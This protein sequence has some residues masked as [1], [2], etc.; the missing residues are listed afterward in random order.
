MNKKD[1]KPVESGN[2]CG[3]PAT[4]WMTLLESNYGTVASD[5]GSVYLQM[6]GV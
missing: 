1:F 2:G 6:E 4:E 5:R 3:A